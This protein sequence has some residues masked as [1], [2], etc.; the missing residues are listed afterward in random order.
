M[1]RLFA[2]LLIL[3]S[4]LCLGGCNRISI[5]YDG[6]ATLKFRGKWVGDNTKLTQTL[7]REETRKV[8]TYLSFAKYCPGEAGCP[9]DEDISIT[10]GDQVIAISY[11]DCPTVWLA[12]SDQY[13]EVSQEARDYIVSLFQKYV[14]YFPFPKQTKA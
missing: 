2:V 6:N 1:K 3:I 13:Y 5:D 4:L 14:G 10:F 8:M 7:T 9:F 11:D 12:G